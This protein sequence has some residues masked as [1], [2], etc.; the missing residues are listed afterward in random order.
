VKKIV[1]LYG[2]D[3]R[4]YNDDGACFEFVFHAHQGK[5]AANEGDGRDARDRRR[6]S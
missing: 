5:A 3:I 1:D 2:G 4:A 6:A